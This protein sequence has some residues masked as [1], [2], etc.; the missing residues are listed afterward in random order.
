[1]VT[2]STTIAATLKFWN[3]SG[4]MVAGS[5]AASSPSPPSK[6][7]PG[8]SAI[9]I[10]RR[11]PWRVADELGRVGADPRLDPRPGRA[12]LH[13]VDDRDRP[14]VA[15]EPGHRPLDDPPRRIVIFLQ[16]DLAGIDDL[17][18]LRARPRSRARHGRARRRSRRRSCTRS[19]SGRAAAAAAGA[20]SR[21]SIRTHR[22]RIAP[23]PIPSFQRKLE[24]HFA[25]SNAGKGKEIPAFA[26]MTRRW[27]LWHP[28]R[29][30]PGHASG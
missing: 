18:P 8:G 22:I 26:G 17:A 14:A 4:G 10:G 9:R 21:S 13:I 19:R 25:L 3:S 28:R 7:T 11:S 5:Q 1:M 16:P 6:R 30:I 29:P 23:R 15:V 24:S 12:H 27:K 2:R 20:A